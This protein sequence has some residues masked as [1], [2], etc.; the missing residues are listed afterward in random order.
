M[1][2]NDVLTD[3]RKQSPLKHILWRE[4][5]CTLV[6]RVYKEFSNPISPNVGIFQAVPLSMGV[7]NTKHNHL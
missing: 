2:L 3:I 6:A 7:S 4:G 5:I 1:D